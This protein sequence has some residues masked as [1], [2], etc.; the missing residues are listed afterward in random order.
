MVHGSLNPPPVDPAGTA[1]VVTVVVIVVLGIAADGVDVVVSAPGGATV[2]TVVAGC[3]TVVDGGAAMVN[4]TRP[5]T[6]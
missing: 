5:V 1:T 4:A 3:G 2:P 6:A